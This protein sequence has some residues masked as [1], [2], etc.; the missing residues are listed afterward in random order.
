MRERVVIH[1]VGALAGVYSVR[2]GVARGSI[3]CAPGRDPTG[4]RPP[5][6]EL[7]SLHFY[8]HTVLHVISPQKYPTPYP[9]YF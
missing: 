6:S 7:G 8:I 4:G 1:S 2:A 5:N 3:L 9:L